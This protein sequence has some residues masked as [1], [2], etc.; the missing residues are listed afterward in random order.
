LR[1]R[2]VGEKA[3]GEEKLQCESADRV[4]DHRHAPSQ[5][6]KRGRLQHLVGRADDLGIHFVGALCRDQV[7][8]LGHG[9][10]V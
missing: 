4:A 8:N 7:G 3:G 1:G 9:F 10:D 5:R 2:R 6:I